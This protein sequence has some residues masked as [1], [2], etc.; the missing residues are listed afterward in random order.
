MAGVIYPFRKLTGVPLDSTVNQQVRLERNVEKA[1]P[2]RARQDRVHQGDPRPRSI[3]QGTSS[4][5]S[6]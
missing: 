2:R 6:R 5:S 3:W 1:I 4:T